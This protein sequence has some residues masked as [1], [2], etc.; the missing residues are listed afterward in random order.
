MLS[1][2]SLRSCI[3]LRI[4]SA[5]LAPPVSTARR[6]ATGFEASR[7]IES[8]HPR[9]DGGENPGAAAPPG[10]SPH[11]RSPG[12]AASPRRGGRAP[13]ACDREGCPATRARR[14]ACPR[15][16]AAGSG[17]AN[18][19]QRCHAW[20]Q[21]S[22]VACPCRILKSAAAAT[23]RSGRLMD[24]SQTVRNA[25]AISAQ[26]T[27]II[28]RNGF[29]LSVLVGRAQDQVQDQ[30]PCRHLAELLPATSELIG[31]HLPCSLSRQAARR[32][33]HIARQLPNGF[34]PRKSRGRASSRDAAKEFR[35]WWSPS[36]A[37][38]LVQSHAPG[39]RV[40]PEV[41]LPRFDLKCLP[42]SASRSSVLLSIAR[43]TQSPDV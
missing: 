11:P 13:S 27:G 9:T 23:A 40:S 8:S 7:N 1:R 32:S 20:F 26:S 31:Q 39:Q 35:L 28:W 15:R 36:R 30:V 4:P 21:V 22:I 14:S 17:R 10:S 25:R 12:A 24:R 5:R 41:V 42:P 33:S 34:R 29:A 38:G 37:R 43:S 16:R 2:P 18:P 3:R 6:S 19:Y